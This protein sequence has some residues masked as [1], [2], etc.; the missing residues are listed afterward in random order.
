MDEK[1]QLK[2]VRVEVGV[3]TVRDDG[4]FLLTE[5]IRSHGENT[6]QLAGGHLEFG[7]T[8]GECALRETKE[9]CGLDVINPVS[10]SYT[11]LTLPTTPYV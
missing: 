4:K 1:K 9:E 7:E 11:H 10:V 2:Q 6:Y 8:L 3:F 5:R